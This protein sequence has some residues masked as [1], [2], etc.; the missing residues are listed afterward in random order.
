[1]TKTTSKIH[2]PTIYEEVINN[3]IYRRIWREAIENELQNL[4]NYHI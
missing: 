1:M 3:A 2:K 4:K